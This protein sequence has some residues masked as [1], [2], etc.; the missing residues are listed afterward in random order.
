MQME[1]KIIATNQAEVERLSHIVAII[2]IGGAASGKEKGEM[3]KAAHTIEVEARKALGKAAGRVEYDED[4]A[5]EK[6]RKGQEAALAAGYK[7]PKAAPVVEDETEDA[8]ESPFD[9]IEDAAPA[10]DDDEDVAPAPK[11]KSSK[12]YAKV[13]PPLE[14]KKAAK[15]A[16]VAEESEDDDE[17]VVPVKRGRGRPPKAATV[18]APAPVKKAKPAPAPVEDEEPGDDEGP[19]VAEAAPAA[20]PSKYTQQDIINAFKARAKK[21]TPYCLS[22]LKK[23]NAVNARAIEPKD[24]NAVM[25]ALA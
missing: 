2:A 13:A 20:T 10:E 17:D 11:K 6:R 23:Y 16:P 14:T 24:Y 18:E 19:S 3:A 15:P 5:T 8:E 4:D 25:K 22:L 7:K 12:E 21:D 9:D 1:F